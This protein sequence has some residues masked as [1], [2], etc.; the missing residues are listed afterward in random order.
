MISALKTWIV[1]NSFLIADQP[2]NVREIT[3]LLS[4][5]VI[6]SK[7]VDIVEIPE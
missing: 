7:P 5:V 2:I 3:K 4:E 1:K 6:T